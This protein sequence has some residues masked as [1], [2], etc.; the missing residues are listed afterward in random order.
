[1]PRVPVDPFI[2]LENP[3]TPPMRIVCLLFRHRLQADY[4]SPFGVCRRC[5]EMY[6]VAYDRL[7]G[8]PYIVRHL[9][10]DHACGWTDAE[11]FVPDPGC[12]VHDVP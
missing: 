8:D 5:G 6:A 11:G 2:P 10:C 7:S 4:R 12:P 9:P 1:M 3:S